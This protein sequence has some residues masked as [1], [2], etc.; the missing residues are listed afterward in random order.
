MGGHSYQCDSC[1]EQTERY[2]SCG[3]RHCPQC[4]GR[5]RFDFAE[6]ASKLLL[7]D[8]TYYQV[9][10]TLP[11]QLSQMALANRTSIADLLIKSAWKSLRKTI[12]SQQGYSPAA[13]MVLH[14]WN[15][16]LHPHWHVHA[17]VPGAGPS[18]AGTQWRQATAPEG[19]S[20]S[21][22]F[23]LVDAIDL[24]ESF[25]RHAIAHLKRLRKQ[26]K[27]KLEGKFAYLQD[28]LAWKD[29]CDK[30][31]KLDWVSYIQPPPSETTSAEQVVRYLTR[32]LTG[33]PISDSRIVAA[34]KE[35]ITFMAREGKQTGGEARQVP[36]T[37][38]TSEFIGRW[39]DH[40]QPIQLTKTR[41]FGGWSNQKREGYLTVCRR[42]LGIEAP[43]PAPQEPKEPFHC[44]NCDKPKMKH[45][46]E[47]PKPTWSELFSGHDER[48]PAWYV[49]LPKEELDPRLAKE[50]G[51]D[52]TGTSSETSLESAMASAVSTALSTESSSPPLPAK[53]QLFL[54]EMP[55]A[56]NAEQT[57]VL[58]SG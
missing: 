28:D 20:N 36:V 50:L 30:L 24:R 8:I 40:I 7:P 45:L 12:R 39:C 22:G 41:Y 13:M 14:T 37:I 53:R 15:Q 5:K 49:A 2:H 3:D 18:H 58:E 57:D 43:A 48:C 21:D 9:V 1:G 19:S 42:L 23:Y 31:S 32:Y 25:R 35:T 55:D 26:G 33:G 38:P 47:T 10:F 34:D 44:P 46:R 17:L 11:S 29:F 16:K 54:W 56:P 4:S 52:S 6:R 27:L 51:I